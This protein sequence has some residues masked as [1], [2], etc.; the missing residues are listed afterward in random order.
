MKYDT[1]LFDS[2]IFTFTN[3]VIRREHL[4]HSESQNKPEKCIDILKSMYFLFD[5]LFN[6]VFKKEVPT[7]S[8][9]KPPNN[10]PRKLSF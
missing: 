8:F 9:K 3:M 4:I 7:S 2:F 10:S 5:F 6:N 1:L